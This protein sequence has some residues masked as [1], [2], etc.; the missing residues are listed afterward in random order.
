MNGEGREC[1]NKPLNNKKM[2]DEIIDMLI[3]S[4][5]DSKSELTAEQSATIAEMLF[6]RL[7]RECKSE[8]SYMQMLSQERFDIPSVKHAR[9]VRSEKCL[10]LS[11]LLFEE[12]NRIRN[13][14]ED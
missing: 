4:G 14:I 2:L 3:D 1:S 10:R 8:A 6:R 7:A 11:E 5:Y 13:R 9:K 12:T